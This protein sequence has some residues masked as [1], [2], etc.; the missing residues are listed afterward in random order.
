MRDEELLTI[1]E[2]AA[3]AKVTRAAI[4]KWIRT[5]QLKAVIVGSHMRV[6]VEAWRAFIRPLQQG[7]RHV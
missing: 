7:D 1:P 2:V 6:P 3:R 4:Y 5:G